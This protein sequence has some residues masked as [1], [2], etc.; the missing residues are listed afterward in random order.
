MLKP[1]AEKKLCVYIHYPQ[2]ASK[3]NSLISRIPTRIKQSQPKH[4]HE[5]NTQ[6]LVVNIQDVTHI[7]QPKFNRF[8]GTPF[9][10]K[11]TIHF[12]FQVDPKNSQKAFYSKSL[13]VFLQMDFLRMKYSL[14]LLWRIYIQTF[15]N[16]FLKYFLL[17]FNVCQMRPVF[18]AVQFLN[19]V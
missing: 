18:N 3:V 14:R 2:S 7:V 15:C 13:C 4:L 1:K 5:K 17:F 16:R 19:L 10:F 6:F 9:F 11:Q 8:S 12:I